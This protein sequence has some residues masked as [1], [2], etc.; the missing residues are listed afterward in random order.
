MISFIIVIIFGDSLAI[1][2]S[3]L[4]GYSGVHFWLLSSLLPLAVGLLWLSKSGKP[5]LAAHGFILTLIAITTYVSFIWGANLQHALLG[6]VL[7]IIIANVLI[8]TT[9]SVI[10][11]TI[12][13]IITVILWDLQIR[14]IIKPHWFWQYPLQ[15]HHA[16]D[17]I[18]LFFSITAVLWLSNRETER[19]AHTAHTLYRFAKV[20]K[21]SSGIFHDLASPLTAVTLSIEYLKHHRDDAS[22]D[23]ESHITTALRATD[24][25]R[26]LITAISKNLHGQTDTVSV[27]SVSKEIGDAIAV[28]AYK[29]RLAGVHIQYRNSDAYFLLGNSLRFHQAIINVLANAIDACERNETGTTRLCTITCTEESRTVW[30]VIS[31]SGPEIPEAIRQYIF[32]PFFTTKTKGYGNGIGL[33]ITKEIVEKEFGGK[34]LVES[35]P[36][37]TTFYLGFPST[38]DIRLPVRA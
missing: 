27:F 28:L 21:L 30:V 14:A 24:E 17:F 18:I 19:V 34:V 36:A 29:S 26:M 23:L 38:K 3:V 2:H 33:S 1:T 22:A 6:S 10:V 32:D 25:M 31:N 7:V 15:F 20:G 5:E 13:S 4:V 37:S 16:T 11:A 9:Y 35:T 8:G 12:I